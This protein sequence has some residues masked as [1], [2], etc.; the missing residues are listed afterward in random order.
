MHPFDRLPDEL[1]SDLFIT[2]AGFCD[3]EFPIHVSH[4]Y[5]RWRSVALGTP[6][7]WSRI[8]FDKRYYKVPCDFSKQNTWLRRSQRALL[9]IEFRELGAFGIC[10]WSQSEQDEAIMEMMDVIVPYADQW[11]RV[12]ASPG[13]NG[14]AYTDLTLFSIIDDVNTPNLESIIIEYESGSHQWYRA[15]LRYAPFVRSRLRTLSVVGMPFVSSSFLNTPNL[16]YLSMGSHSWIWPNP[17]PLPT[18]HKILRVLSTA[19]SLRQLEVAL[20][21]MIWASTEDEDQQLPVEGVSSPTLEELHI[22]KHQYD[23]DVCLTPSLP[24]ICPAIR[25]LKVIR[26]T[27][28][29]L[30]DVQVETLGKHCPYLE[31]IYLNECELSGVEVLST[32]LESRSDAGWAPIQ[33]M[34]VISCRGILPSSLLLKSHF[35]GLVK[36]LRFQPFFLE[37]DFIE[38]GDM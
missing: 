22:V 31:D 24:S 4:V 1:I 3:H 19:T 27:N 26:L 25:R 18:A 9:T 38:Y 14:W 6:N 36:D 5:R 34:E 32:F 11:W 33:I 15:R 2:T 12:K 20:Y 28:V 21:P 8:I 7:L 37:Q 30:T 16:Q 13:E 17:T 29:E 10:P 35:H 23:G